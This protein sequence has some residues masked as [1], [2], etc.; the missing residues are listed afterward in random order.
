MNEGEKEWERQINRMR[1]MKLKTIKAEKEN[2]RFRPIICHLY[3]M[4]LADLNLFI[5]HFFCV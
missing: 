5:T 1:E 2:T 4:K 3:F